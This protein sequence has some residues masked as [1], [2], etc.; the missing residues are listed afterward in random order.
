MIQDKGSAQ[1]VTFRRRGKIQKANGAQRREPVP[2][3]RQ[4]AGSKATEAEPH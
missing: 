3:V 2:S 4:S 1:K